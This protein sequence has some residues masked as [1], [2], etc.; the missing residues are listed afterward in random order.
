MRSIAYLYQRASPRR[1]RRSTRMTKGEAQVPL[2]DDVE[3][4][5]AIDVVQL[6]D[7][8]AQVDDDEEAQVDDDEEVQQATS[9]SSCVYLR[10]P[11]SPPQRPIS[12]ERHSLIRLEGQR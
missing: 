2:Q 3:A 11:M 10:G 12:R 7:E 1:G 5:Q 6:D 4:Q 8:E 9:G